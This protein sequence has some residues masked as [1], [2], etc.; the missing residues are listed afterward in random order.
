M[1]LGKKAGKAK[2][3]SKRDRSPGPGKPPSSSA[4]V[5]KRSGL[6]GSKKDRHL[7]KQLATEAHVEHAKGAFAA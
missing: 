2:A 4:A 6:T 7:A 3:Q 5:A 1:K